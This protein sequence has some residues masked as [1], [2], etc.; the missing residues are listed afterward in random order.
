[1]HPT[2]P[3]PKS[4]GK[5]ASAKLPANETSDLILAKLISSDLFRLIRL[6]I[7]QLRHPIFDASEG[8]ALF[9]MIDGGL[10][11]E[12]PLHL[13]AKLPQIIKSERKHPS[14]GQNSCTTPSAE[15]VKYSLLM[16]HKSLQSKGQK[17]GASCT[18][19]HIVANSSATSND[20]AVDDVRYVLHVANSGHTEAVLCRRG[21][22]V[23]LTKRFIVDESK[24]EYDRVRMAG[25]IVTEVFSFE[26]KTQHPLI[27]N[28]REFKTDS[29]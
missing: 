25:S 17:L 3:V 11:N 26:L 22:A 24:D 14:S 23:V 2:R 5:L 13:Q 1:M 8:D 9:G 10:N 20:D 27:R 15:Y 4:H 12:I 21:V 16:A 29:F 18:L 6:C 19:C 28:K 7:S